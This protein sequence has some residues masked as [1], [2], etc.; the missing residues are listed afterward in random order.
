M[1]TASKEELRVYTMLQELEDRLYSEKELQRL[2]DYSVPLRQ[3]RLYKYLQPFTNMAT[4][5]FQGF[6][7]LK[8]DLISGEHMGGRV[9]IKRGPYKITA[10]I[11]GVYFTY[12]ERKNNGED[13]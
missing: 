11:D 9:P 5:E 12:V 4:L 13:N 10:V 3:T 8:G 1:D 2:F 6:K 7:P